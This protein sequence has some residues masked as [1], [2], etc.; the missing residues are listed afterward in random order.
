MHA[1]PAKHVEAVLLPFLPGSVTQADVAST[2]NRSEQW[3]NGLA[4]ISKYLVLRSRWL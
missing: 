3:M 1:T 2:K 4:A